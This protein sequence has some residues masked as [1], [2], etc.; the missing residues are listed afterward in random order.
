MAPQRSRPVARSAAYPGHPHVPDPVQQLS[1]HAAYRCRVQAWAGSSGGG[2]RV[3]GGLEE[4][5][6]I[7][8]A[9]ALEVKPQGYEGNQ[10]EKAK[11]MWQQW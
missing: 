6:L 7:S 4:H 8:Q 1:R 11:G 3:E 10:A 5:L 9:A 2:A